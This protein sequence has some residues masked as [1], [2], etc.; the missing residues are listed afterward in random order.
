[1][2]QPLTTSGQSRARSPSEIQAS[3][4]AE[5]SKAGISE[6]TLF[7]ASPS[8][9][10]SGSAVLASLLAQ[11]SRHLFDPTSQPIVPPKQQVVSSSNLT[12]KLHY[13]K[14]DEVALIKKAFHFSDSAHLGQYR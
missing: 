3:N 14:P 4:T 2:A 11:S 5:L 10:L 7:G 6:S 1:V 12:A 9:S 8:S 13:L